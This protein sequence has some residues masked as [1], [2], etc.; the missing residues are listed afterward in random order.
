M[1]ADPKENLLI[2][3]ENNKYLVNTQK[4]ASG[5][6]RLSRIN[7]FMFLIFFPLKEVILGHPV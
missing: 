3:T 2:K 6:T 4:V 7:V 5:L 1:Y